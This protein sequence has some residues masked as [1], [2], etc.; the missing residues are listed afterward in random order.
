MPGRRTRDALHHS[1]PVDPAFAARCAETWTNLLT[2]PESGGTFTAKG[3]MRALDV[4]YD[5]VRPVLDRAVAD[6]QLV[7]VSPRLGY[8]APGLRSEAVTLQDLVS[9]AARAISPSAKG[10]PG[11]RAP[12]VIER[13]EVLTSAQFAK[14]RAAAAVAAR[15]LGGAGG[16]A[17]VGV[18]H[19]GWTPTVGAEPGRGRW[20]LVDVVARAS[21]EQARRAWEASK[22]SGTWDPSRNDAARAAHAGG[23]RVLLDFAR[24]R[25]LIATTARHGAEHGVHAAEW[26]P[27]VESATAVVA[28]EAKSDTVRYNAA[29]G[30]RTLALYG[31]LAGHLDET[32]VDW[33]RV[34]SLIGNAVY[35]ET[36]ALSRT[37]LTNAQRAY[38]LLRRRGVIE[39]SVW[40]AKS[41][42]T[43]EGLARG[44]AFTEAATKGDFGGW[45][46]RR[47]VGNEPV[48]VRP[49]A[50]LDGP[51]AI[52]HYYCWADG[53]KTSADLAMLGL[54]DRQYVEPDRQQEKKWIKALTRGRPLFA[55]APGTLRRNVRLLNSIV[56]WADAT[57]AVDFTR[58]GL[59][60][61]A[62]PEVFERYAAAWQASHPEA[63]GRGGRAAWLKQMA[64]L[65]GVVANP[66]LAARAIQQGDA[67]LAA[68]MVGGARKLFIRSIEHAPADHEQ[69]SGKR[70]VARW[71]RSSRG[72]SGVDVLRAIRDEMA[73]DLE[74]IGGGTVEEQIVAVEAGRH[75]VRG[76][77]GWAVLL[78]DAILFSCQARVA[79]RPHNVCDLRHGG[80]APSWVVDDPA[81]PWAGEIRYEFPANRMKG[82]EEFT[83][84][85][86]SHDDAETADALDDL[87]ADLVQLFLMS[88]GGRDEI[89]RLEDGVL[90]DSPF[91][92]PAVARYGKAEQREARA[93]AGCPLQ[94]AS[95]AAAFKARIFEYARRVG[96]DPRELEATYGAA[97]P[98]VCRALVYTA[99]DRAGQG[100][101]GAALLAHTPGSKTAAQHYR[102]DGGV[103]PDQIRRARER[104][105]RGGGPPTG[106][107]GREAALLRGLDLVERGVLTSAAFEEL[108]RS[109]T[110]SAG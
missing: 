44:G 6:G 77:L 49:D 38:R 110:G 92:F 15:A 70:K 75:R 67:A 8:T 104:V 85:L 89:R 13:I 96:L 21:D 93:A 5:R 102:G 26:Q 63:K 60:A 50:L 94:P 100:S 82:V 36:G 32:S 52:T 37:K 88:G 68:E 55:N 62:R 42:R 108:V 84:L 1:R 95:L 29:C 22:A 34:I 54:P 16:L 99:A 28:A 31:T 74:E 71:E 48:L 59:E 73:A 97:A 79:L 35:A 87:R 10:R 30:V 17:G 83:A 14:V 105:G 107:V 98:H 3:L 103:T 51:Y 40:G 9:H 39:G 18:E 86:I 19:F 69:S 11:R 101:A 24:S 106:P 65:L 23:I 12:D 61:V 109:L 57:G 66:F 2:N 58:N 81:R 41:E 78:R 25:G 46:M 80:P 47:V 27:W 64:S 43:P 72:R 76:R 91:V 56:G 53:R 45:H 33:A 7:H 20:N 4:G 90:V